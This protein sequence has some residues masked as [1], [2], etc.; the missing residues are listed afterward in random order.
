MPPH[1][2]P[3]PPCRLTKYPAL[4]VQFLAGW[5]TRACLKIAFHQMCVTICGGFGPNERDAVG[6]VDQMKAKSP[7]KWGVHMAEMNFQTRSRDIEF[8]YCKNTPFCGSSNPISFFL[9]LCFF[10]LGNKRL[11]KRINQHDHTSCH[12]H[13]RNRL[14]KDLNQAS[15]GQ[16][17]GTAEV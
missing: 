16:G 5:S 13:C 17:I 15:I 1:R 2:L 3:P 6:C 10:F 12:N 7:A 14:C 11:Y 8:I 4:A 9:L